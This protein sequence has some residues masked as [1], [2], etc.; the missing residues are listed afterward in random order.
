MNEDKSA[1]LNMLLIFLI[2]N[3]LALLIVPLYG[4]EYKAFQGQEENPLIA[5]Y[6]MCLMLVITGI[7]LYLSRKNMDKLIQGI[8]LFSIGITMIYV[9]TPIL[10]LFVGWIGEILAIVIGVLLCYLVY[11]NPEWYVIDIVGV[12]LSAGV[13]VILGISLSYIPVIVFLII[14]AV[15][16]YIAV[17]KTKHMVSLAD[18]VIENKLPVLF[19]IPKK[20]GYSYKKEK[21]LKKEGK[22]EA[23]FMG[24]GDVIIP[25]VLI[26]SS[27]V[28]LESLL[29]GISTMLG[30]MCGMLILFKF[31]LKGNPQ[32]GL[33]FLNSGAL[34]GFSIGFFFF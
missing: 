26:I 22:R 10:Y 2:S 33:L 23:M 31:V 6:Y 4:E 5:V 14:L 12:L 21:G 18:R 7:V 11:K 13:A 25:G 28:Y 17:Y 8:F 29:I 1:A 24:Y 30:A 20:K 16:D 32:S 9:L 27:Y 34:I 15:Y 3:L 19:V